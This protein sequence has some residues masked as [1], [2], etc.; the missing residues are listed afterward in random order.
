[1][2]LEKNIITSKLKKIET[3]IKSNNIYNANKKYKKLLTNKKYKEI[4][5]SWE[6]KSNIVTLEDIEKLRE[7]LK[8]MPSIP[9]SDSDFTPS[10]PNF[11]LVND[12][13]PSVSRPY[14]F[15]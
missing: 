2:N 9:T 7:Y 12:S 4:F 10:A 5:S 3:L 15:D 6:R 1:M 11:S 14:L 8:N 13:I